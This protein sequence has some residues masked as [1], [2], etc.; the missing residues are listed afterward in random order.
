MVDITLSLIGANTDEISLAEDSDFVAK[1]GILGLGIPPTSVRIDESASDGG[2]WRNS[3]RGIRAID[4][5]IT[6]LGTS[7]QDVEEKMRRLARLVQDTKGPT[8]IR[9]NYASGEEWDLMAH[10][11]GG[12]ESQYGDDGG[13]KWINWVLSFQ[14]PDPFWTRTI[15]ESYFLGTGATGRSLIPN[16]AE[17]RVSSSQAIGVL[18]IENSGDVPAYPRWQIAGPIDVLTVT[19]QDGREFVY[20]GPILLGETIFIDTINGTVTDS[21]GANMYQNLGPSPKLFSI[22]AGVTSLTVSATGADEDSLISM[23]YQPRKEV[24]H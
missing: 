17:M 23:F 7:R 13:E 18:E 24:V 2:V 3:K 11:V 19:A 5:P 22:P 20:D 4:I 15:S 21:S 14:A 16:L 1:R 10:Y 8:I 9:A 12:S 6:I